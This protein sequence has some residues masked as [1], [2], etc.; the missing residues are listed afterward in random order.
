M[1]ANIGSTSLEVE[2]TKERPQGGGGKWL[3]SMLWP[4]LLLGK[5]Q[6]VGYKIIGY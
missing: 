2:T 5:M 3:F 6:E 4:E 1:T